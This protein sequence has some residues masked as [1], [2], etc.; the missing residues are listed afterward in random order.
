MSHLSIVMLGGYEITLGGVPASR[1]GTSKARALLGYLAVEAHSVHSRESLA[2]LLW[3]N[4]SQDGAAHSLRQALYG[5]RRAL[6]DGASE[7]AYL[8][9]TRRKVQFDLAADYTLD[10]TTFSSLLQVC[11]THRHR[12]LDACPDCA[13]RLRKAA[14]LYRGSFMRGFTLPSSTAFEEWRTG[15]QQDLHIQAMEALA[16]LATYYERARAYDQADRFLQRQLELEPW[17]EQ[18]HRARMRVLALSGQREAAIAQYTAC[19]QALRAEL[20]I[21]PSPETAQLREQILSG[22]LAPAPKLAPDT[23]V[24]NPYKG[25]SAFGRSDAAD[26]CGRE[27]FV[28]RLREA[29][30]QQTTIIVLG[31]SGSGKTSLVQAGLLPRLPAPWRIIQCRPGSQPFERLAEAL[32]PHHAAPHPPDSRRAD[33]PAQT[34]EDQKQALAKA[35]REG[36]YSLPEIMR[37]MVV[38]PETP[39]RGSQSIGT[40]AALP[41]P[42]V[43]LLIDQFEELYTL[44]GDPGTQRRYLDL[45]FAPALE[46]LADEMR[47]VRLLCLRA[48]FGGQALTYRPLADA[49]QTGRL[50]LGPMT[51]DELRAAIERPAKSHGAEFEPGLVE[52]L[53]DDVGSEPGNLPLLQFTLTQ[54]WEHRQEGRLT[55]AAYTALGGVA[56]AL[57]GYADQVYSTLDSDDQE[58]AQHILTQMVCPGQSTEDTR[59]I[60]HRDDLSEHAWTLVRRLADARLVITGSDP[61]GIETAEL[62]HEALIRTWGRLRQWL[63]ADQSFHQWQ[64]RLRTSM[65]QWQRSE[66]D[67]GALLRGVLLSEA[68]QWTA[69]RWNSLSAAQQAYIQ[70][71][72]RLHQRTLAEAQARHQRELAHAH[73]LERAARLAQSLR[74]AANA[75]LALRDHDTE[76]ALALALEANQIAASDGVSSPEV[77]RVLA[78]AAYAPGTRRMLDGHGPYVRCVAASADGHTA[79]SGGGDQTLILWDLAASR[80]LQRFRGHEGTIYDVAYSPDGRT[81]LSASGD[82]TLILWDLETGQALRRFR[83]HKRWVTSVAFCSDGRTAVSGSGDLSLIRWDLATGKI[84]HRFLDHAETPEALAVSHDG[85]MLLSGDRSGQLVLWDLENGTVLRKPVGPLD[86][87]RAHNGRVRDIAFLPGSKVAITVG[88]DRRALMWDLESGAMLRSFEFWETD[89]L[90]SIDLSPDGQQALLGTRDNMPILLHLESGQA[91]QTTFGRRGRIECL[92]FHPD[93]KHVV[94]GA[95]DGQVRLSDLFGGAEIRHLE[96]AMHGPITDVDLGPDGKRLLSGHQNHSLTLWDLSVAD[97]PELRHWIG[98]EAPLTGGVR[99][100]PDGR[101]ALSGAGG[102]THPHYGVSLRL[103]EIGT[104][105]ELCR[106]QGHTGPVWAIDVSRDGRQAVSASPDGTVRRWK[107]PPPDQTVPGSLSPNTAAPSPRQAEGEIV[108]DFAPQAP[109]CIAQSPDGRTVLVGLDKE[110]ST[111]P[112]YDLWLLS[113]HSPDTPPAGSTGTPSHRD[114][115]RII[116][117]FEGHHEPVTA[118]AVSLSGQL[119]LS[120]AL[121]GSVLL[122]DVE[123]GQVICRL[124][125]HTSSVTAAAFAPNDQFAITGSQDGSLVVW[126]LET[127]AALRH[128]IGHRGQVLDICVSQDSGSVF[129]AGADLTVREW[130]IDATQDALMAWIHANRYVPHLTLAQREQYKLD[131]LDV[132]PSPEGAAGPDR[133][134]QDP[135]TPEHEGSPSPVADPDSALALSGLRTEIGD[136]R[137]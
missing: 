69:Q 75:R 114:P 27:S 20:S 113:L 72:T 92:V 7:T 71:S 43:L 104:G 40:D 89:G 53:L 116:R 28:L 83:G 88:E 36:K 118:L 98:H 5:L 90:Y 58:T 121:S 49:I 120:G 41:H 46:R 129:S 54:L 66:H 109:R 9:V 56:G 12:S 25:L 44:C 24:P 22:T 39:T 97:C 112:N 122:W 16:A 137:I 51:R 87:D 101:R 21:A 96:C 30:E 6:S 61:D 37:Q 65:L 33:A 60:V 123:S 131:L 47:L 133:A 110:S 108:Y 78:E 93:G 134:T 11:S 67:E 81:A 32:L 105:R 4:A 1:L 102:N 125:E 95:S 52:R 117:R 127:G 74:L 23:P 15:K 10:V 13:A 18:S 63:E 82:S 126:N 45:L 99:F 135:P 111:T 31:A 119:A 38:P 34:L 3:P 59:R 8:R 68:R 136:G 132:E 2:A 26:F 86:N 48:D 85:H 73:A 79:L 80:A 94:S 84:V 70:A 91:T 35:L 57:T 115:G 106:F 124:N 42:P 103:W 29:V 50:I 107:L 19:Q 14:A 62:V 76:L 55:H 17:N 100:L 128:Y 130:R 77:Q 64:E